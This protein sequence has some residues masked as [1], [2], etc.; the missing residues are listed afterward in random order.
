ML[1]QQQAAVSAFDGL[2]ERI[3]I[4]ASPPLLSSVRSFV[5]Y[6]IIS[7]FSIPKS[8]TKLHSKHEAFAD[9][10]LVSDTTCTRDHH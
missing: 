9:P 1:T 6:R 8:S 10:S 3:H 4:V 2:Y 5:V 7:S